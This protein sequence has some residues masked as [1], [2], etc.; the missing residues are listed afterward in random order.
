MVKDE[1]FNALFFNHFHFILL[2]IHLPFTGFDIFKK[3]R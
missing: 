2:S 1:F 3:A